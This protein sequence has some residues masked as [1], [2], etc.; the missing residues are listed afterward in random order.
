MRTRLVLLAFKSGK[1]KK[2]TLCNDW[3]CMIEWFEHDFRINI[4]S[5]WEVC[6]KICHR[7]KIS[8]NENADR[9]GNT[10]NHMHGVS[11]PAASKAIEHFGYDDCQVNYMVFTR[12]QIHFRVNRHSHWSPSKYASFSHKNQKLLNFQ[13]QIITTILEKIEFCILFKPSSLVTFTV[14]G[15]LQSA[16]IAVKIGRLNCFLKY[17]AQRGRWRPQEWITESQGFSLAWKF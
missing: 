6:S 9:I 16:H 5:L 1:E 14:D 15:R 17:S 11:Q 13:F 12:R 7:T 4:V 2:D 8:V 3:R 10:L